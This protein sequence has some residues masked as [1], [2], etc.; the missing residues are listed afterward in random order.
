LQTLIRK[1]EFPKYGEWS[2]SGANNGNRQT[3]GADNSASSSGGTSGG[4]ESQ[5]PVTP[6]YEIG[7]DW[8][9]MQN[10]HNRQIST[11]FGAI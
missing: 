1:E 3:N 7:P 6:P 9:A 10:T 2:L 8:T 4:S 5:A 11:K